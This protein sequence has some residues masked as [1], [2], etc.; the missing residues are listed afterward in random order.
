[1]NKWGWNVAVG[2]SPRKQVGKKLRKKQKTYC[3]IGRLRLSI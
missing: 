3:V 2:L 1:M